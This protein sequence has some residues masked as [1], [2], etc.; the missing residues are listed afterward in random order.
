MKRV[1][2]AAQN[3]LVSEA[4]VSSLKKNDMIVEKA[5]RWH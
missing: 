1:V 2:I 3:M 5:L 4:V